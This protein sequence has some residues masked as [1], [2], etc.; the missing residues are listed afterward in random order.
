M[1]VFIRGIRL[2]PHTAS[3][4]AHIVGGSC[5]LNPRREAENVKGAVGGVRFPM[6]CFLSTASL[7]WFESD[8]GK[9]V[10]SEPGN[11][12]Q[13]KGHT[14]L[15]RKNAKVPTVYTDLRDDTRNSRLRSTGLGVL[16]LWNPP[17]FP[18]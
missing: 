4:S 17:A 15:Q 10:L 18:P 8:V 14:E 3:A 12:Q 16:S 7:E 2:M 6:K 1:P 9:G 5:Q 13:P 11:R